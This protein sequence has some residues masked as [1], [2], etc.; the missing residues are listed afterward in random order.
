M[1]MYSYRMPRESPYNAV[2]QFSRVLLYYREERNV[3]SI[4]SYHIVSI[5]R[6]IAKFHVQ[7][8][9]ICIRVPKI[10]DIFLYELCH[11]DNNRFDA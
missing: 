6:T 8:I 9:H 4:Y 5:R 1:E 7:Y 11:L 3:T 10:S 2:K